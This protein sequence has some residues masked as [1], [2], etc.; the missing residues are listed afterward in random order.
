MSFDSW[1][2]HGSNK[3]DVFES[4]PEIAHTHKKKSKEIAVAVSGQ[5]YFLQPLVFAKLRKL[6]W[7]VPSPMT[8]FF[9]RLPR[10]PTPI[11]Y[12]LRTAPHLFDILLN[13]VDSGSLPDLTTLR[14][15]D[16]EELEP[17][18]MLLQLPV[19]QKHLHLQQWGITMSSVPSFFRRETSDRLYKAPAAQSNRRDNTTSCD[20]NIGST[21]TKSDDHSLDTAI[22]PARRHSFLHKIRRNNNQK[23][24]L[25]DVTTAH[26]NEHEHEG[27]SFDSASM[28][29]DGY[30]PPT[31]H[32]HSERS[33]L[34]GTTKHSRPGF[35]RKLRLQSERTLS[36]AEVCTS[37]D[38][39][40]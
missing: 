38:L 30:L 9:S 28:S 10:S 11:Q 23:D 33:F 25:D 17:L 24:T 27:R 31:M 13:Y 20:E 29:E 14:T 6:P 4:F 19:L 36:H 21:T 40:N 15:A 8:N 3:E 7:T 26:L 35:L 2:Y 22:L 12:S 39:I 37:S 18:V 5:L 1:D 32:A 34:N 16:L